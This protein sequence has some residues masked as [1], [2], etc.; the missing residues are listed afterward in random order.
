MCRAASIRL[1]V[2]PTFTAN[3]VAGSAAATGPDGDRREMR[4]GRGT[5]S[6]SQARSAAASVTSGVRP[7]DP[8]TS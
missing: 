3:A 8:M 6:S 4:H 5:R 7:D 2:P 1:I